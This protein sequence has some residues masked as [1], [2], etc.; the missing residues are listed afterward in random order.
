MKKNLTLLT[1][2]AFVI[3]IL[4]AGGCGDRKKQNDS[5]TAGV[6]PL[7]VVADS[8]VEIYLKEVLIDEE[9]HLEMSDSRKPECPVIDNLMTVVYPENTVIFMN[10]KHG[11]IDEVLEVRLVEVGDTIFSTSETRVPELYR[12]EIDPEVDPDT[13]K[14][15]IKFRVKQDTTTW[16][17]DPYLRIPRQ[18]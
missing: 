18:Q 7:A 3:A 5:T 13:I 4:I 15:L 9:M 8:T 17:I 1:G 6:A 14:Y 2:I 16:T 12:L 11:R 10:A